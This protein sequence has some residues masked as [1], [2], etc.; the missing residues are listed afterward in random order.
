[1]GICQSQEEKDLQAKT[2]QIDR[3]LIQGHATNSK[4]VKLLLLGESRFEY[5]IEKFKLDC[6]IH[7]ESNSLARIF[8]VGY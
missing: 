4:V 3:E 2:K 5:L 6:R 1:M 8:A 7:F